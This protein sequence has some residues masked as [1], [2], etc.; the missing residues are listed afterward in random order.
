MGS[1][2]LDSEF[3][4]LNKA[5]Q[6]P[7]HRPLADHA[8]SRERLDGWIALS[9]FGVHVMRQHDKQQSPTANRLGAFQNCAHGLVAHF[10]WLSG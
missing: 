2:A 7:L 4:Q 9:S 1:T 8:L 3:A 6:I 10:K 5:F